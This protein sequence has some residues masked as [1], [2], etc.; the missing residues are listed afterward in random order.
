[1]IRGGVQGDQATAAIMANCVPAIARSRVVGLLTMRDLP[2]LP[3][4]KPRARSPREVTQLRVTSIL[5]DRTA[6]LHPGSAALY[7]E[8]SRTSSLPASRTTSAT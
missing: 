1:M 3:Y 2:L 6:R 7:E 8:S 4:Y 5:D